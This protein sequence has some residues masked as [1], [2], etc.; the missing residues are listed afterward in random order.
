MAHTEDLTTLLAVARRPVRVDEAAAAL[1]IEAEE[2]LAAIEE[3]VSTGQVLDTAEGV[4]LSESTPEP[5]SASRTSFLAGRWAEALDAV[6]G[7]ATEIGLAY[8]AASQYEQA[9]ER[10]VPE[11]LGGGAYEAVEGALAAGEHGSFFSR[12]TEGQL[13]FLRAAHRD[14]EGD[15]HGA[16]ADLDKAIRRLEGAA[17][18][19]ALRLAANVASNLQRPQQAE[20]LA[21][22]AAWEASHVGEPAKQGTLLAL[23]GRELS[24]IGFPTEADRVMEVGRSLVNEY[25]NTQQKDYVNWNDA[26]IH[27]DRGEFRSAEAE[28]AV[29]R[30]H[31]SDG[32]PLNLALRE[33]YWA[34][35]LFGLGHVREAMEAASR[36][37]ELADQHDADAP[38]FI[39]ELARME[40]T[41]Y[42]GRHEDS[43]AHAEK[44]LEIVRRSLPQWENMALVGL[45]R[46]YAGLGD[47]ERATETLEAALAATPEGIDGWRW[48]IHA[49]E[50]QLSLTPEGDAWPQK[51]AEDLTDALLQARWFGSAA[52]LMGVRA[53]RES[54]QDLGLEGAALALQIGNPMVAAHAAEAAGAWDNPAVIPVAR[55]VRA[56]E[57]HLPEDWLEDWKSHPAVV[58]AFEVDVDV[59]VDSDELTRHIDEA[60]EAAGLAGTDIILS[61]AQRQARGLVRRRPRRRSPLTLVAAAAGIVLLSGAT[62][63]AVIMSTRDPVAEPPPT[64]PTTTTI[65]RME[66]T[67]VSLPD[68]GV[69]GTIEYRGGAQRDGVMED[70]GFYTPLGNY[71]V[72]RPGGTFLTDPM[73]YGRNLVFAS[74]T[75]NADLILLNMGQDDAN[76]GERTN[77]A[78][79]AE[80][81]S[82]PVTKT[83]SQPM[84][85]G[86]PMLIVTTDDGRLHARNALTGLPIWRTPVELGGVARG[87]PLIVER[88]SGVEIVVGTDAGEVIGFNIDGVELWRYA[89]SER[90]PMAP[91][92]ESIAYHDGIVYVVDEA[93]VLHLLEIP[94]QAPAEGG[95]LSDDGLID[96]SGGA[97]NTGG[98]E[99][100]EDPSG[101]EATVELVCDQSYGALPPGG[102]PIISDGVVYIPVAT[103][104][105]W[106]TTVGRCSSLPIGAISPQIPLLTQFGLPFAPIVHDGIIYFVDN[107]RIVAKDAFRNQQLYSVFNA[108]SQIS[109]APVMAGGVIYVGTT[110]GILFAIDPQ[111][112]AELWRFDVGAPIVGSPAPVKGGA[113]FVLTNDGQVIAIAAQE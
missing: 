15:N 97:I 105:I 36:A 10:L 80:V 60:L 33:A 92:T 14:A 67:T 88:A 41:G 46:A 31:A 28:F 5:K 63:F 74:D 6:G 1:R 107:R 61:P 70:G 21:A 85:S 7:D 108:E 91:I 87:S 54:F 16:A 71:F 37:Y 24:R 100:G 8:L 49:Q 112:R 94:E 13:H 72:V 57:A 73:A 12:A 44:V 66:D 65:P 48:R 50:I 55:A 26:W 22:L 83:V 99:N 2:V 3:L 53:H 62:A 25:G 17:L 89:G 56:L 59:D 42:F 84:A 82:A 32:D 38:R 51:D 64:I 111:T 104:E 93:G 86:L 58:N 19:D 40:G 76:K 75:P 110:D 106:M 68:R 79:G 20:A 77:V 35:S 101:E 113:V 96:P 47:A 95:G 102:S 90:D 23:H 98:S 45:A 4:A 18:V 27:F 29:L 109:A 9:A 103:G 11:A 78:I 81:T 69:F 52:H 39:A 30:D 34:R 43:A